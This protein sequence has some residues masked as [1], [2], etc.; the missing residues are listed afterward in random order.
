MVPLSPKE[1]SVLGDRHQGTMD[2]LLYLFPGDMG[3]SLSCGYS[4]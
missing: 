3:T 1:L 4:S 2:P